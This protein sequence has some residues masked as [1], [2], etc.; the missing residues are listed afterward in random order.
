MKFPIAALLCVL[1]PGALLAQQTPDFSAAFD[2][3]QT[4]DFAGITSVVVMQDGEIVAERYF[5][6]GGADALCHQDGHRH[7]RGDRG[8]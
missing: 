3:A 6:D 1:T 7:A 4:D 2:A 8:G 5:D